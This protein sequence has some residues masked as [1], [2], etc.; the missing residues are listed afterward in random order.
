MSVSTVVLD[1]IEALKLEEGERLPS[2]RT[3]AE[4]C[5]VSRTSIRNAL[6]ELQSRRILAVKK[7]SGYFL[8]SQFALEQAVAGEDHSWNLE[9]IEQTMEARRHVEPH[10]IAISAEQMCEDDVSRLESCLVSL[11]EA[12]VGNDFSAAVFLHR[13]FFKI[14]QD[15]CPNREFVRMLSEV[16]IPLSYTVRVIE[17]A[18]AQE[19]NSLFSE[20]VNL[21]QAI[22]KKTFVETRPICERI[23]RLATEL[24]TKYAASVAF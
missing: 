20:H 9:R 22:K 4:S 5:N 18:S 3:L 1:K 14:I 6:K 2:E 8:A 24:F 15:R 11:G 12:T 16:R 23:N 21:L 10:V 17:E 13:K 7:G 19:R